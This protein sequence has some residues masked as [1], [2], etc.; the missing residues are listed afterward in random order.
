MNLKMTPLYAESWNVAFRMCK[1]GDILKDKQ[2]EFSVIPNSFNY[3]AA[4]PMVFEYKNEIFIFAE[5]YDYKLCR[6]TIGYTKLNGNEFSKWKQVIVEDFH[7]SYPNIFVKDNIVYMVPETSGANELIMYKAVEFPDKWEKCKVIKSGV[8]WVDTTFINHE[9]EIV[10]FTESHENGIQDIKLKLDVDYNLLSE[11]IFA[12]DD[13]TLRCGG[14]IFEYNDNYI[15]VTQDC[16]QKYGGAL[17]FRICD[18]VSLK[19]KSK[20]HLSPEE[21]KYDKNI[22]LDGMHTYTSLD[23]IEV[24]DIKTRRFN[25]KN[26]FYRFFSKIR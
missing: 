2:T 26:L 23:N 25:I 18:K 12:N 24:I 8:K 10:A 21:L 15:W 17:F 9:N 11:D 20:I 3:W 6:G 16:S 1:S 14:R 22:L 4:D 19:E 7:M 5:L 13:S